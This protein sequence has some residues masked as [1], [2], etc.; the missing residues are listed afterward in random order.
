MEEKMTNDIEM[1]KG[2]AEIKEEDLSDEKILQDYSKTSE[3]YSAVKSYLKQIGTIK[4]LTVEE[5]RELARKIKRGD[6]E[7]KKKFIEANLRLVV[8]VVKNCK[9]ITTSFEFLDLVQEGNIGLMKAVEKFDVDKGYKF[10]TYAIWWIRKA[11]NVAKYD[12]DSS[13]RI[14][15]NLREIYNQYLTFNSY[16]IKKYGIEPTKEQIMKELKISAERYNQLL[17]IEKNI[18]NIKSL[19]SAISNDGEKNN[20]INFIPNK[21]NGYEEIENTLNNKL[22]LYTLK[23]KITRAEYYIIYYRF[24]EIPSKTLQQLAE[25]FLV[26]RERIRQIEFQALQKIKQFLLT[27][28]SKTNQND[29]KS[30]YHQDLKP[31]SINHIIIL[32]YLKKQLDDYNYYLF[33]KIW[34]QKASFQEVSKILDLSPLTVKND[35]E[36][37]KRQYS[38]ILMEQTEEFQR[39]KKNLLSSQT[40]SKV[41][42][43]NISPNATTLEIT[44]KI[45]HN[46]SFQEACNMLGE[47]YNHLNSHQKYLFDAYFNDEIKPIYPSKLENVKCKINL[48]LLGYNKTSNVPLKKLYEVFKENKENFTPELY[49]YLENTLFK[50]FVKKETKIRY[51]IDEKK[52]ISYEIYRLEAMYY[53]LDHYFNYELDKDTIQKVLST[54]PTKFSNQAIQLL[55]LR[56]GIQ[57]KQHSITEIAKMYQWDYIDTHDILR[58]YYDRVV[59]LFLGITNKISISNEERYLPF[60]NN[61]KYQ[62]TTEARKVCKLY[63]IEHKSYKE[64]SQ[65]LNIINTTR[66]SNIL[67]ESLRKMDYWYYGMFDTLILEEEKVYKLLEEQYEKQDFIKRNVIINRFI[68]GKEPDTSAIQYNLTKKEVNSIVRTFQKNYISYYAKKD[69]SEQ[70]IQKE[71]TCHIS[72][73]ILTEKERKILSLLYGIKCKS[74]PNGIKYGKDTIEIL[75]QMKTNK[76]RSILYQSKIKIGA[77][78]NGIISPEF[79]YFTQEEIKILLQDENIPLSETEKELLKY[80]KGINENEDKELKELSEMFSMTPA[81][82]K[83]RIKRSMLTL[84]KYCNQELDKKLNYERDILPLLKYFPLFDQ[85]IIY[86]RYKLNES[87]EKIRITYSLTKDEGI[88]LTQRIQKRLLYLI[89]YPDAKKFDFDYARKV[90]SE[91]ALPYYGNKKMAIKIYNMQFGEDGAIPK[92]KRKIITELGLKETENTSL[93]VKSLMIAVLKY[94]DG[95]Y[96]QKNISYE[97]VYHFYQQNKM[98]YSLS[99]Q[100]NFERTLKKLEKNNDSILLIK[101]YQNDFVV[102]EILKSRKKLLFDF[103]I[104]S[105]MAIKLIKENPFHLSKS[106]LAIIRNYFKISK[107]QLMSGKEKLKLLKLLKPFAIK[108][109]KNEESRKKLQ[110]DLNESKINNILSHDVTEVTNKTQNVLAVS[111]IINMNKTTEG[112]VL[113]ADPEI[114]YIYAYIRYKYREID[115]LVDYEL[116]EMIYQLQKS[117]I[118]SLKR[119]EFNQIFTDKIEI[120]QLKKFSQI[121]TDTI[122]F[123]KEAIQTDQ[124]ARL[125]CSDMLLTD[126]IRCSVIAN[127]AHFIHIKRNIQKAKVEFIT[128]QNFTFQNN[129][130][131]INLGTYLSKL[132]KSAA[133]NLLNMYKDHLTPNGTLLSYFKGNNPRNIEEIF[134]GIPYQEYKIAP[135]RQNMAKRKNFST[136]DKLVVAKNKK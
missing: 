74:N 83:R 57:T 116:Y 53:N 80:I 13:I 10:S 121:D 77:R 17:Q 59:N 133:I 46:L 16:Y 4:L 95:I 55:K 110:L 26:T 85:T 130:E 107:R 12:K 112:G 37:T 2:I 62:M 52:D 129:Y 1:L 7:A 124:L 39:I 128:R 75:E 111:Q 19:D 6:K 70:D 30:I 118:L 18:D 31:I 115:C 105:E 87:I 82:T 76:I 24:F 44:E 68:Y 132:E 106:Q 42:K 101:E 97:E 71:V 32:D 40:I 29:L 60:L 84:K 33:Y 108:Y 47:K 14:P 81:S 63:L 94:K 88:T 120:S 67:T 5:E 58:I 34:F 113:L 78:I 61:P 98:K 50:S 25:E 127:S 15:R 131:Q 38:Q 90:L 96:K 103:N 66:V 35:Y 49:T 48:E 93:I 122:A 89:K 45:I 22:L 102:Y 11:I 109:L 41:L 135:V 73:S 100:K 92:T 21:E 8:S 43:I 91:E 134:E 104:S 23:N 79:G 64:I 117:A 65:E 27:K 28:E 51:T 36:K 56:Y 72:D 69:L 123:W 3:V 54:N 99:S 126:R 9:K 125:F 86:R 20:L 136:Y 114:D 119:D